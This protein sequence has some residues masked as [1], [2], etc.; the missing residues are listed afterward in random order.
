MQKQF[1]AG[2]YDPW[3]LSCSG[4]DLNNCDNTPSAAADELPDGCECVE[5]KGHD[6]K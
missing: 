2:P 5:V 1:E 3:L 4:E 6:Y